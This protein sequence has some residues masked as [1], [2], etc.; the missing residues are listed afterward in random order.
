MSSPYPA[1]VILKTLLSSSVNILQVPVKQ[2]IC[3]RHKALIPLWIASLVSA[4]QENRRPSRVKSIEN[5]QLPLVHLATQFIHVGMPRA[6]GRTAEAGRDHQ[7]RQPHAAHAAGGS[8]ADRDASMP[9][10]TGAAS[11]S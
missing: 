8:G 9:I 2:I 6:V 1:P 10:S 4:N 5:T 7:A 3:Y 11:C